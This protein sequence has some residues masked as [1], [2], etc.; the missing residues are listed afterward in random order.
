MSTHFYTEHEIPK[1]WFLI[2]AEGQV[3][4]RVAQKAAEIIMGKNK[5]EYSPNAD[6]GDFVIITNAAK[7]KLSGNKELKK[8]YYR[9]S[10]YIGGLSKTPA[11]RQRKKDASRM[12]YR[13]VWGMIRNGTLARKQMTKLRIFNQA[14]HKHEAQKPIRITI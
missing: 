3:L 4:G 12:M 13:A 2:D 9:H 7:A 8:I 14:N 5:P 1:K 11:F 6:V 10:G